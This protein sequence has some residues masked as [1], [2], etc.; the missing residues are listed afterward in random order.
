MTLIVQ[1]FGG[2]SVA[3]PN[4]RQALLAQVNRCRNEGNDVVVVVSAM[5]RSG[6]PYATDTLIGLL[7]EIN[8]NVSP[9]KKDFLISCGEIISCSVISHLLE[10]NNI[11]SEPL[12]GS[13]AGI[14]TTNTFSN[15]EI[16]SIDTTKIEKYLKEGK[17][18]V[19]AG[20]QGSTVEGEITTLG[21]G[22]SDISGVSIGGYLNADRVDIFT[23]VLG[24]AKIDPRIIPSA[25]YMPTIT[26][27]DMFKL[28]DHGAKVIHPRAVKVAQ[29]FGIPVRVRSTFSEDLGTLI[30]GEVTKYGHKI[31]GFALEKDINDS[32]VFIVFDVKDKDEIKDDIQDFIENSGMIPNDVIWGNGDVTLLFPTVKIVEIVQNLYSY[33]HESKKAINI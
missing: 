26:Y 12:T 22:G 17:V 8:T 11:P 4:A 18:V 27:E 32:K 33:L 6:D 1:K 10:T 2:T 25:T 16:I 28:A 5:G 14:I 7:E 19:I 9:R 15:S 29:E 21:R 31:I 30:T 24:I 3:T 13:Q 23:D 20:F